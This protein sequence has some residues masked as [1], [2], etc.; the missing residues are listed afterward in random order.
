LVLLMAVLIGIGAGVLTALTGHPGFEA[1]NVPKLVTS[2]V[3]CG[4]VG[5]T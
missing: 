1:C 5:S 4:F 2:P 3:S